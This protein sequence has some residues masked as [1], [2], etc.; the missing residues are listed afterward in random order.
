[1]EPTIIVK[2]NKGGYRPGAGKKK[3]SKNVATI[4]REKVLEMAKDII[5]GRTRRLIDTQTILATGGIKVYVMRS[6]WEGSGKTKKLVKGKPE[7]VTD[8]E[9]ICAALDSEFGDGESPNDEN[10]Y[11]FVITKDPDNQAINSLLD[12][13]FGRTTENKTITLNK[14]MGEWLDEIENNGS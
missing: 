10:S 12:R 11:Y 13:T 14:G 1:M 9:E 7:I 2:N 6:H 3:G 4:E 5:A 8:D